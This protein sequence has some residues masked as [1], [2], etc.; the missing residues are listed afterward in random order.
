MLERR[1]VPQR[2]VGA[3][4]TAKPTRKKGG[5]HP[6][7]F[8]PRAYAGPAGH[9]G[10]L[11]WALNAVAT[12]AGIGPGSSWWWPYVLVGLFAELLISVGVPTLLLDLEYEELFIAGIVAAT[13]WWAI[14][15]FARII[16]GYYH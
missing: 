8:H 15:Q 13:A 9:D 3:G 6:R 11:S 5:S 14:P 2:R 1:N 7:D 16:A 4:R 12:A 10:S